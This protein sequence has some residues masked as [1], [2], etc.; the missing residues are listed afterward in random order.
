MATEPPSIAGNFTRALRGIE[1]PPRPEILDRVVEELQSEEPDYRRLAYL[2]VSDA[3]IAAGLVKTANAPYFGYRTKAS[4]VREALTMLGLVMVSRTVAGLALRH[5]LPEG[6]GLA[7]FWDTSARVARVSAW[8]VRQLGVRDGVRGQ[9]AHTY[10]LFR[11]C[12]IPVLMRA[13]D[14]YPDSLAAARGDPQ[15]SFTAV[16]ERFHGID[17]A[18]VG[19]RLARSWG[20]PETDCLAIEHHHDEDALAAPD[21]LPTPAR[22]LIALGQLSDQ[23]QQRSPPAD[24]EWSKLGASCLSALGLSV[25]DV[26]ALAEEARGVLAAEA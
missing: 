1:I 17:H 20:L 3:G 13:Y 18:R 25:M 22:R 11:D 24:C 15:Q 19:G 7:G 2:V 26:P 21:A 12:G 9:D 10:G 16:E 5:A 8:L 4:T 23:L 6:S 14:N